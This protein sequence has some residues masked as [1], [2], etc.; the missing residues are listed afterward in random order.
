MINDNKNTIPEIESITGIAIPENINSQMSVALMDSDIKFELSDDQIHAVYDR[1]FHSFT[2]RLDIYQE[3]L[4]F[5]KFVNRLDSMSQNDLKLLSVRID[6]INDSSTYWK[7]SSLDGKFWDLCS[8][9]S[10]ALCC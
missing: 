4:L 1:I 3:R 5:T 10:I 6:D 8:D 2:S 9:L 7:Q